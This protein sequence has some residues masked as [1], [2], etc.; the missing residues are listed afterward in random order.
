MF[1]LRQVYCFADPV[2]FEDVSRWRSGPGRLADPELAVQ[3]LP[4]PEGWVRRYR[5]YWVSLRPDGYVSAEQGWKVHVSATL[6]NA[7]RIASTV[8]DYCTTR[9]IPFKHLH[10]RNMLLALNAK[11]APRGASG[12]M[13]TIYPAD[14]AELRQLLE[15]LATL[16]AGEQG[17]YILSDLR[18][19]DG[20]LYVR[21]GAFVEMHCTDPS[22]ATVH[23][24]R[25]PDGTLVPDRRGP[26]FS[27]PSW[28]EM[29]EFL[30]PQLAARAAGGGGEHPY[31]VEKTLHFS[32]A[33]GVYLATRLTDGVQVVLKEARPHAGLDEKHHDGV[34]RL[35]SERWAL[36]KLAGVPG[37]PALYDHFEVGGHEFI[38]EEYVEG[39]NLHVWRGANHPWVTQ[40]EPTEEQ[41]AEFTERAMAVC[42]RVEAMIRELHSRG[43]VFGDL[44]LGN[45]LVHPDDS[46][47][48]IDFELAFDT[49]KDDW[50]P[51]LGATGFTR[52]DKTGVRRDLHGLAAL[53]LALFLNLNRILALEPRKVHQFV[54]VVR[55]NFP[56]PAGW[57]E[58]VRAELA[59]L[60]D[61]SGPAGSEPLGVDL[62]SQPIDWAAARASM[63][64]AVHRS[65]SPERK[66]RLFPGDVEQFLSGGL[67]LAHGAAGVLWAL[68][69]TGQGRC[70][71]HERWLVDGMRAARAPRPGF[72]DGAAGVAY[73]LDHLGYADEAADALERARPDRT[74]G[75]GMGLFSGL[76][77]LSLCLG[78]LGRRTGEPAHQKLAARM[79]ER[80]ADA[81]RAGDARRVNGRPA[82]GAAPTVDA[83]LMRGWSG[84]ALALLRLHEDTGE[85]EFLDLAVRAVHRDL[86]QCVRTKDGTLQVEE[87]GRRTLGYLEVGSAGI[88]LV[89]DELLR[90]VEDDRILES[91]PDLALACVRSF[92]IQPDLFH[93]RAGMLAT[94]ARLGERA[95]L[96]DRAAAVARHL[97]RLTWHAISYHGQLAFPGGL[98]FRLSMDLATGTAGVLLAVGTATR[99]DAP[100]LPFFT[101]RGDAGTESAGSAATV[102]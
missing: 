63:A 69:V 23:A 71:D 88:A 34:A 24:I 81:V 36:E 47:S 48:L 26:V 13:I 32:N 62:D 98:G 38:V 15:D 73:A 94:V 39:P 22:G 74:D 33:G 35:R 86:D 64:G 40:A 10:D 46:V 37:V 60:P 52:A 53:R 14:E 90:R 17:P 70:P 91:L 96:P 61:T 28:V 30:K 92:V 101:P 7:D 56:V 67:G 45:V 76:A 65:A 84:V 59:P 85:Q 27:P 3:R 25:R 21:Y 78:H 44:H 11:Y 50:L 5:S 58:R 9:G 100:F 20:P 8:W 68:S 18:W 12:K 41:L 102:R 43:V 1:E 87:R 42:D 75:L 89:C 83:G 4:A 72:Y 57:A 2:F 93:G 31:R 66:D 29:P 95:Q 82:A 99:P 6:D 19:E 79:G 97:D 54:D 51:G 55:A 49:A 16:L 77:G 80:L